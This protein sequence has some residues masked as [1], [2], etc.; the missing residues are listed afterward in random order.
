MGLAKLQGAE[1]YK[2]KQSNAAC[3]ARQEYETR[4]TAAGK[5]LSDTLY[6]HKVVAEREY[7]RLLEVNGSRVRPGA[8][9]KR[10]AAVKAHT[11]SVVNNAAAGIKKDISEQVVTT[12]NKVVEVMCERFEKMLDERNVGHTVTSM[13]AASSDPRGSA[14]S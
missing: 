6:R 13:A 3:R 2:K 14:H 9:M 4:T 8:R 10:L 12:G 7:N 11:S 1:W 5:P